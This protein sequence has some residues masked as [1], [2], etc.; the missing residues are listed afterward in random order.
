MVILDFELYRTFIHVIFV[1]IHLRSYTLPNILKCLFLT[2]FFNQISIQILKIVLKKYLQLFI[3]ILFG[4]YCVLST[5]FFVAICLSSICVWYCGTYLFASC[6]EYKEKAQSET[7]RRRK[8]NDEESVTR[9]FSPVT[10]PF[11]FF[12]HYFVSIAAIIYSKAG[13]Y[14]QAVQNDFI[15]MKLINNSYWNS[16]KEYHPSA[17]NHRWKMSY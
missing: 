13:C 8:E 14:S 16:T 17:L 3:L 6:L 11:R 9:I 5:F 2:K 4:F 7:N 1:I 15:A 10:R 12:C